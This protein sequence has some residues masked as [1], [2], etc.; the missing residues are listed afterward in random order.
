MPSKNSLFI[1]KRFTADQILITLKL[2]F[3]KLIRRQYWKQYFKSSLFTTN[4]CYFSEWYLGSFERKKSINISKFA[5][6]SS[7]LNASAQYSSTHLTGHRQPIKK[8][9][10]KIEKN[11]WSVCLHFKISYSGPDIATICPRHSAHKKSLLAH[12]LLIRNQISRKR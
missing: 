10:W 7:F 3:K 1:G 6:Y 5:F 11:K 4:A 2:P 12:D 9:L 8:L